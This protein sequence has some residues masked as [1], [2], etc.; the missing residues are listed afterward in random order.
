MNTTSN[1][2]KAFAMHVEHQRESF[3]KYQ[4]IP[5]SI[6]LVVGFVANIMVI[7][8]GLK[9]SNRLKYTTNCF[10]LNLAVADLGMIVYYIPIQ[11]VEYTIGLRVSDWTCK[12]II[13]MRETFS[14]MSVVTV[15]VLGIVRLLQLHKGRFLS[16]RLTNFLIAIMWLVAYCTVSLPLS[17][18]FKHTNVDTC[19]ATWESDEK[20]KIHIAFLNTLLLF[21]L[22]ITNLC[23]FCIILKLRMFNLSFSSAE[24]SELEQKSQRIRIL[25]FMLIIET[26]LSLVPYLIYSMLIVFSDHYVNSPYP[27]QLWSIMSIL[28]TSTSAI[29]PVLILITSKDYR[30]E[31]RRT[32]YRRE[33]I[34]PL[35]HV[36]LK[37]KQQKPSVNAD[38]R[39][40][41]QSYSV[42]ECV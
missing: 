35:Q 30:K 25:M 24:R 8:A 31:I 3:R 22:L 19:D 42:A 15:G 23:Y 20:K 1:I 5:L 21:W 13:P 27:Y 34:S 26:W 17:I 12:Y 4:L 10:I 40:P 36:E 18:P 14:I 9:K 7:H 41:D 6:I 38:C 32:F 33:R 29:N 39:Y 37:E 11:F 2:S 16:M 28:F